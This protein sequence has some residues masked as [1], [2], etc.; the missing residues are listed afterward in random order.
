MPSRDRPRERLLV[1][2]AAARGVDDADASL[3]EP[4]HLA[5]EQADRLGRLR[6]V[7]RDEVGLGHELRRAARGRRSSAVPGRARRT[8]RR[9]AGASRTRAHAAR[10]ACRPGRGRRRPSTLSLSS[11]P[12]HRVRSQRP[13]F[14][15]RV[16]LRDVASLREQQRQR[17]L[18]G[19]Q[20]V[21]LRRVHHH[22]A[23][24]RGR[25]DVDVVEADAG[26]A[27]DDEVGAR[28]RAP[29]RSP[30]SPSG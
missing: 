19:G 15:R 11:T 18:G 17:V 25:L 12:S 8:G 20:H 23:A 5:V 6:E 16:R 24:T 7:D 4:E 2:D 1:D 22:H 30:S 28:L 10:R 26:A 21:R 27:D 13:C 29:R 14:E 3:G 9:R